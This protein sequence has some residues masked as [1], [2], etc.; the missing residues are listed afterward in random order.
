MDLKHIRHANLASLLGYYLDGWAD[1]I[2]GMGDKAEEVENAVFDQLIQQNMPDVNVTKVS[3]REGFLS[4]EYRDYIKTTTSPGATTTI[5][6][7]KHGKNL[8][9]SWR[10]FILVIPNLKLLLIYLLMSIVITIIV[11]LI[12]TESIIFKIHHLIINSVNW[13]IFK[14]AIGRWALFA[15]L[16]FGCELL[17]LVVAGRVIRRHERA[18]L[19]KG[20][21]IIASIFAIIIPLFV[22]N[23]GKEIGQGISYIFKTYWTGFGLLLFKLIN[24][25]LYALWTIT[26]IL[27]LAAILGLIIRRNIFAFFLKEPSLFDAEDISAMNISVHKVILRALDSQ[28]IDITKLRIKR[29]FKG[30]RREENV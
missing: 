11:G 9:A 14:D 22:E 19:A 3:M 12:I 18:F 26:I 29:D 10:S 5:Y 8:Y 2:E 28:G 30:G 27:V 17:V 4:G 25:P 7:S 24:I 23:I 6:F 15:I 1:L 16:V 21:I 20:I 13:E